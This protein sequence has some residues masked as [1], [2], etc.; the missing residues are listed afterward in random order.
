M[1]ILFIIYVTLIIY[2][3]ILY[4]HIYPPLARGGAGKIFCLYAC[5]YIYILRHY[6]QIYIYPPLARGGAGKI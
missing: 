3:Y 1:H 6:K 2:I 5:I 4:M